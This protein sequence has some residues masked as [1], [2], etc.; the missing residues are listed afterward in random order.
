MAENLSQQLAYSLQ[1]AQL[2]AESAQQMQMLRHTMLGAAG[3]MGSLAMGAY[4]GMGNLAPFAGSSAA[5]LNQAMGRGMYASASAFGPRVGGPGGLVYEAGMGELLAR[6]SGGILFQNVNKS[7]SQT[8]AQMQ[9]SA[10]SELRL[11]G[12][13]FVSSLKYGALTLGGILDDSIAYRFTGGADDRIKSR[14]TRQLADQLGG[15]IGRTGTAGNIV[16]A[17]VSQI[18]KLNADK[19]GYGLNASQ[20]EELARLA[21]SFSGPVGS[22]SKDISDRSTK[23]LERFEQVVGKLGVSADKLM[24]GYQ[25]LQKAGAASN[26]AAELYEQSIARAREQNTYGS[27]GTDD[28]II[29]MS[30]Q[31]SIAAASRGLRGT[32]AANYV[33]TRMGATAQAAREF[34]LLGLSQSGV[35]GTGTAGLATSMSVRE[36]LIAQTMNAGGLFAQVNEGAATQLQTGGL[37]GV[38]GLLRGTAG[39]TRTALSNPL[40]A[41]LYKSDPGSFTNAIAGQIGPGAIIS[42]AMQKL[43]AFQRNRLLKG[44]PGALES[45]GL[46]SDVSKMSEDH[47]FQVA[48]ML[49]RAYGHLD[50]QAAEYFAKTVMR[51]PGGLESAMR[52]EMLSTR[53]LAALNFDLS[54]VGTLVGFFKGTEYDTAR[55]LGPFGSTPSVYDYLS[56]FSKNDI[57]A[58]AKN[59]KSAFGKI[60]QTRIDLEK[61]YDAILT[62]PTVADKLM[63]NAPSTQVKEFIRGIKNEAIKKRKEAL[64]GTVNDAKF[65]TKE[66]IKASTTTQLVG[67][68]A[69]P[70]EFINIDYEKGVLDPSGLKFIKSRGS[71]DPNFIRDHF[72]NMTSAQRVDGSA[73]AK[74]KPVLTQIDGTVDVKIVADVSSK[75]SGG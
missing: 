43:P 49:A 20:Q 28:F 9:D 19:M 41:L 37:S 16:N 12:Q 5:F 23:F 36:Q 75:K 29:Q 34:E 72:K 15:P 59:E 7:I 25:E 46:T 1:Q 71:F 57:L 53:Q 10:K 42:A 26:A 6:T 61:L 31:M 52:G 67:D 13:E 48:Q 45:I 50:P 68:Y 64:N 69:V 58:V 70:T 66:T 21:I 8:A 65:F 17:L 4:A 60:G 63:D 40:L 33:N 47:R 56:S 73:N 22:T 51:T 3:G 18:G 32:Q 24:A 54:D 14:L 62:D 74:P 30:S 35:F 27:F 11:R 2:R 39:S 55:Q 38:A 44:L